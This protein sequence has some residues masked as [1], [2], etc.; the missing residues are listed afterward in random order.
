MQKFLKILL[1]IIF[2]LLV[3]LFLLFVFGIMSIFHDDNTLYPVH[4]FIDPIKD[5]RRLNPDIPKCS[6]RCSYEADYHRECYPPDDFTGNICVDDWKIINYINGEPQFS[7]NFYKSGMIYYIYRYGEGEENYS[8]KPDCSER[9]DMPMKDRIYLRY[10]D[11]YGCTIWYQPDGNIEEARFGDYEYDYKYMFGKVVYESV[12]NRKNDYS[13]TID[14]YDDGSVKNYYETNNGK[15]INK[16]FYKNGN[17]SKLDL[18]K[19]YRIYYNEDNTVSLIE[20]KWIDELIDINMDT[21][22]CY[23]QYHFIS[24]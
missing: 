18:G 24:K 19:G 13:L 1:K 12:R 7:M 14:Y 3:I 21:D 8:F 20:Y 11:S 6:L 10:E 4:V 9:T 2:G 16:T 15:V 17:L 22:E 5:I 23:L